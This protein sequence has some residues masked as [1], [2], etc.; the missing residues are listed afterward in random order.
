MIEKLS[1]PVRTDSH[2]DGFSTKWVGRESGRHMLSF[3]VAPPDSG[4]ISAS[5]GHVN[6]DALTDFEDD[7]AFERYVLD[8]VTPTDAEFAGDGVGHRVGRRRLD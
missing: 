5:M 8:R 4:R 2:A 1:T 6:A 3:S 7:T